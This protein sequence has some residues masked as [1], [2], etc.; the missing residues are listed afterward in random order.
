MKAAPLTVSKRALPPLR[1]SKTLPADARVVG[2]MGT[3]KTPTDSR[4]I[5]AAKL[6]EAERKAKINAAMVTTTPAHKARLLALVRESASVDADS[7]CKRLL[8]ALQGGPL[9]T[10]EARD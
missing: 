9:T 7:Q 2:R 1:V 8:I 10:R 4:S 3:H 5:V 6:A